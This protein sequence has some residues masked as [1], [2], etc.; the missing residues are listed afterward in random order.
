V[1]YPGE[2]EG[3]TPGVVTS[4]YVSDVSNSE[5]VTRSGN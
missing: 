1:M 3:S 5:L 2:V 4:L